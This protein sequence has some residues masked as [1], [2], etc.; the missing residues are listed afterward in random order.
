MKTPLLIQIQEAALDSN[1]SLTDALR[2]SKIA[3][4]KLGLIEFGQWIE[5]ELSG[6]TNVTVSSLPTYRKLH[7]RSEAFNSFRGW[8]PIQFRS[9]D[10]ANS[11]SIVLFGL[12]VPEIEQSIARKSGEQPGYFVCDYPPEVKIALR[13]SMNYADDLRV[14]IETQHVMGMLNSVRNILLNWTVEMERQGILGEGLM[15]T[16]EDKDKSALVTANTVNTYNIQQVGAFVQIA[17]APSSINNIRADR[18]TVGA[19]NTGE[20]DKIDVCITTLEQ[21]GN[22]DLSEAL[23]TLSQAILGASELPNETKS[24]TLEQVSYLSEQAAAATNDRKPGMIKAACAALTQVA[25]TTTALAT[26]W[27][28]AEPILHGHFGF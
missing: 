4:A 21:V 9:A 5:K 2:K 10:Q 7:G 15:F 28:A 27:K 13:K 25:T 6:Y 24:Q 14:R 23:K 26:A 19:I 11:F 8:L 1:S 17:H 3:C 20:V 12:A 18:S 16:K 22:K